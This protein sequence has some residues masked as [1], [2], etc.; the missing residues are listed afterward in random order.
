MPRALTIEGAFGRMVAKRISGVKNAAPKPIAGPMPHYPDALRKAKTTGRAI[1]SCEIAANGQPVNLVLK[2]ATDPVFGEAALAVMPQWWF[3]PKIE[4]GQPV[5]LR[6]RSCRSIS[7]TAQI[8]SPGLRTRAPVAFDRR[9]CPSV[10]CSRLPGALPPC[11]RACAGV[12][13]GSP[14]RF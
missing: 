3:L 12:V 10:Q 6:R 7:S 8:V 5:A 4:Q 11:L 9:E 2:N 14:G 1:V 13:C